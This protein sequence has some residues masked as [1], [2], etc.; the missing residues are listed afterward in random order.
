MFKPTNLRLAFFGSDLFS[1]VSLKR[2]VSMANETLAISQID[3]FTR[4]IKPSGR[5]LKNLV[6]V[7]VGEYAQ[8]EGLS[9]FRVDTSKQ[10]TQYIDKKYDL[11][12]AVSFGKLIP[13]SFLSSLRY[14]GLNVHPLM[15]PKYSGSS[16]IQYAI[17]NDC[18]TTGVTVQTL[19]PT[20]FDQ[21][22]ILRQSAP[23][24]IKENE[25]FESLR[26]RLAVVGADLLH[27]VV[28]GSL[29][30]PEVLA[31]TEKYS[32]APK[33]PP[34]LAEIQWDH[35]TSRQI[36]CFERALGPLFSNK[37][38]DIVKKK[39]HISG[40][41]K[42]IMED[43]KEVKNESFED[44]SKPGD[45]CINVKRIIA[46]TTDAYISV[47]RLKYECCEYEEPETFMAR[48]KGRAGA[49][50]NCFIQKV[51]TKL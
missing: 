11:A 5:A 4:S 45:F 8:Q 14:G 36:C 17:M 29:A 38:V 21:G 32:L 18:K 46:K 28:M 44:L 19:H 35:M 23:I 34:R 51:G 40:S 22:D 48:L 24:A 26:D 1:L 30:E 2:L 33:I 27:D 20:K 9:L 49:T 41:A 3:V 10:I 7:P 37:A 50:D 43:I 42:V 6:D 39:K 15:L 12:V 25:T 47:G 31:P 16:P 13:G